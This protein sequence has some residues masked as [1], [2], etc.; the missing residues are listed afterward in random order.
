MYLKPG[1][2]Q[3]HMFIIP[4]IWKAEARGSLEPLGNTVS[5]CLERKPEDRGGEE[6]EEPYHQPFLV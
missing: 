2:A 4:G 1:W 6:K 3:W 5:P